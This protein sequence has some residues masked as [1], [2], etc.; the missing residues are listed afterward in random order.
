M[1]YS[2]RYV[3]T[4]T[5]ILGLGGAASAQSLELYVCQNAGDLH[6]LDFGLTV[7]DA[8]P[9]ETLRTR[10]E[11]DNL[12]L[13]EGVLVTEVAEEGLGY[14]AGFRPGDVIYRVGGADVGDNVETA[15]RMS[16]LGTDSDTLV[17]FLRRGRPYRIKLR[18][19]SP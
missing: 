3:L 7:C 2:T 6:S 4:A 17:N 15:A 19:P 8:S 18:Q 16:L 13:R 10:M 11:P 12:Q 9:T 5:L 14:A 1:R